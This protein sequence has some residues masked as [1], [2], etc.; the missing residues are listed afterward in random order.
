MGIRKV[1]LLSVSNLTGLALA[2]YFARNILSWCSV[3]ATTWRLDADKM[4]YMD[5]FDFHAVNVGDKSS[6]QEGERPLCD[7]PWCA[8]HTF[9]G[10]KNIPQTDRISLLRSHNY[11]VVQKAGEE[12]YKNSTDLVTLEKCL[13]KRVNTPLRIKKVD[14][15]IQALSIA[16]YMRDADIKVLEGLL[17][18]L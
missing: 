10:I 15:L 11:Y 16:T 4:I 14:R 1:H 5:P 12:F 8:G 2:A 3:D 18:K 13:K 17:W 6:F 9:T 7:C